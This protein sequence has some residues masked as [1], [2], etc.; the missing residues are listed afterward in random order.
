MTFMALPSAYGRHVLL[1]SVQ[2]Q[3][4]RRTASKLAS[5]RF[6]LLSGRA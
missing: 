5:Q 4:V 2:L 6:W 1:L 3:L